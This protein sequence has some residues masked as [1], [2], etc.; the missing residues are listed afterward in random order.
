MA[1]LRLHRLLLVQRPLF[2]FCFAFGSGMCVIHRAPV[3]SRL[4]SQHLRAHT[5]AV[6]ADKPGKVSPRTNQ[7]RPLAS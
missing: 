7:S 2:S 6:Y 3:F 1:A 4:V 5:V